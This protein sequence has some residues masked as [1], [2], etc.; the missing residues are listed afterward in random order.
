[1][2]VVGAEQQESAAAEIAGRG[3]DNGESKAGGDGGVNGIA[4]FAQ[5]VEAGVGGEMVDADHHAMGCADG[6]FIQVGRDGGNHVLRWR[7]G[8]GLGGGKG[9]DAKCGAG[10]GGQNGEKVPSIHSVLT[11]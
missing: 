9:W 5:H 4:A 7:L 10:K 11:G 1:V 2:A 6:L 3:M 8:A